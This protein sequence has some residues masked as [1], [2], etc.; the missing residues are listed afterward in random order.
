MTA[1]RLDMQI[2]IA[3]LY[4]RQEMSQQEIADKMGLSRTTVSRMLK[5]CIDDGVVSIHIKNTAAYQYE[6]GSRLEKKYGLKRVSVVSD[7]YDNEDISAA[8]GES[9]SDYLQKIVTKNVRI[10]VSAG[11]MI[12]SSA[13]LLRPIEGYSVQ[14]FQ[15]QG[16]I[17]HQISSC[18]SF[19]TY[20]M[21]KAL[22][23]VSHAVHAPLIVHTKVLRDLL[24][25]EPANKR[26]FQ[27]LTSLDIAILGLGESDTILPVQ[28]DSWHDFSSDR[29]KLKMNDLSGDICGS[30]INSDGNICDLDIADRTIAIPLPMLKRIPDCIAVAMGRRKK[31]IA[32]AAIK[33][34]YVNVLIVDES[35]GNA[36]I[37]D[38]EYTGDKIYK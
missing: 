37:E 8:I 3:N 24:L 17:N 38:E 18:S 25:E 9:L 36:L 20:N 28:S 29:A 32:K 4:Y 21:A 23:G 7:R 34:G 13:K 11:A 15:M 1:N 35:L 33:G 16:D 31:N 2:E 30:F 27:E 26:H 19:L 12:K 6:L 10:G 14:V 22:G 5:S